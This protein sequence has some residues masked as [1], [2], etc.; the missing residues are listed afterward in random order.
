MVLKFSFVPS[1]I[2]T[3]LDSLTLSDFSPGSSALS[4]PLCI[5]PT[6]PIP[7][8]SSEW[9]KTH[10]L[11]AQKLDL[12]QLLA[13]NAYCPQETFVP[14]L[15]KTVSS[16]VHVRVRVRVEWHDGT[17]KYLH[18]DLPSVQKV[19]V[20]LDMSGMNAHYQLH[21][22]HALRILLQEQLANKHSFNIIV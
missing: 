2:S 1:Q 19:Q 18:V 9:L 17:V 3:G 20:L 13:R 16:T 22:Q 6:G 14:I 21:L 7:T 10:G 5:Q 12:Y 8:T 11:K 15:E 4:T